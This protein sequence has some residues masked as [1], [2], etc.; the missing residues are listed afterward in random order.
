MLI[1]SH[2]TG[3][4][5]RMLALRSL[6]N[7]AGLRD[8]SV[9]FIAEHARERRFRAGEMLLVPD[10]PLERIYMLV[11]GSVAVTR[12]GKTQTIVAPGAV[13]ILGCLAGEIDGWSAV[14]AEDTLT[15]ELPV[16]A[17]LRNLEEDFAILRNSLRILSGR[18]VDAR[19][20]LPVKPERAPPVELGTLPERDPTLCE[21]VIG[22]RT[23]NSPFAFA[24]M[25]AIIEVARRMEM[26]RL[27]AGHV[28]FEVGEPSTFSIRIQYGRV[29]CMAPTGE[30]VDVGFG[31]VLGALDA[32]GQRPRSY[33]AICETDVV[34]YRTPYEE[35]LTVLEMHPSLALSMLKGIAASL[36]P[37]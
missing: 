7:Y 29:R 36:I 10:V 25:D 26:M 5:D 34:V 15:L 17:F 20:K 35:F 37:R 24:N 16:T 30:H 8:E 14:A 28:L 12:H 3:V 31:M 32:W 33:S 19:G 27:P 2:L 18:A 23:S 11:G 21:L 9:L 6:P 13:G 22:L 4:R 1:E